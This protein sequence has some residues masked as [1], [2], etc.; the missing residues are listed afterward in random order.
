[1]LVAHMTCSQ[2]IP[3]V[4]AV[5]SAPDRL[6]TRQAYSRTAHSY[7]MV[8]HVV[9]SSTG[10]DM[11][12]LLSQGTKACLGWDRGEAV[13]GHHASTCTVDAWLQLLQHAERAA[14]ALRPVP[15]MLGREA[16][17]A[18]ITFLAL[19]NQLLE[20]WKVRGLPARAC[21]L[22]CSA[23]GPGLSWLHS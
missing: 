15:G 19:V 14:S 1:M 12:Q 4:Q 2:H 10:A 6:Q 22:A 17:S 18:A 16:A 7:S 3:I 5:V 8:Q 23:L 9:A 21:T 13:G 20:H 11:L